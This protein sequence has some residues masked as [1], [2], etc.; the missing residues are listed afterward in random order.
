MAETETE[1]VV[2]VFLYSRIVN[3]TFYGFIYYR[4]QVGKPVPEVEPS[5]HVPEVAKKATIK[6]VASTTLEAFA[7]WLYHRYAPAKLPSVE[8][9]VYLA[10]LAKLPIGLYILLVSISLF[11]IFRIFFNDFSE[12]NY[13]RIRYTN[14][15]NL[16]TE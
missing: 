2:A 12:T 9:Y 6:A 7:S 3:S 5:G 13:L 4:T 1:M 8:H 11:F 14:F 15:R 16:F 10:R